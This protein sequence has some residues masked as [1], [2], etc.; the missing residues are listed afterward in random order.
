MT[1]GPLPPSERLARLRLART[2]RVG[3]VAFSAL[4]ARYRTAERALEALPDIARRSGGGVRLAAV[5][6]I[7]AELQRG[8][9]IGARLLVL[10]DPEFPPLL[11]ALDPHLCRCGTHNRIIKAILRAAAESS[12]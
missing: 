6:E 2:E 11:A 7:E 12:S 8:E 10:G 9:A 3:P 1:Q 4:L 5:S